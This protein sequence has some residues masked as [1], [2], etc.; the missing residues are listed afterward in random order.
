M[1][2]LP[3][4]A[5]VGGQSTWC[6][7]MVPAQDIPL[8]KALAMT[9]ATA[10]M[11]GSAFQAASRARAVVL[12]GSAR[13]SEAQPATSR[14]AVIIFV[15][16]SRLRMLED[17]AAMHA[18]TKGSAML[19]WLRR[20][21]ERADRIDAKVKALIRAFGVDAHYEARQRKRGAESAEAAQEWRAVAQAIARKTGRR[22]G[23]DTATRMAMD[24]DFS[25]AR[26]RDGQ[27]TDPHS[28]GM[29]QLDELRRLISKE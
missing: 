4:S 19:S 10:A 8:A 15:R 11:F 25:T 26:Q 28:P 16:P 20:R 2:W 23:L 13:T 24:A 17:Y 18:R 5:T 21:R 27:R 7:S 1:S 3:V 29:D 14:T 22:V 9:S 6:P 12:A